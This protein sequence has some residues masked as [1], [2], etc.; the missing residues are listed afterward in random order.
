M[1]RSEREDYT[2]NARS[3]KTDSIL[4]YSLID[5]H[6]N[7]LLTIESKRL[8][9]TQA[10]LVKY[11]TNSQCQDACPSFMHLYIRTEPKRRSWMRYAYSVN[12]HTTVKIFTVPSVSESELPPAFQLANNCLTS[13]RYFLL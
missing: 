11:E 10:W 12:H 13:A 6:I 2:N 4:K 5:M 8:R 9:L 7:I 1:T 3:K